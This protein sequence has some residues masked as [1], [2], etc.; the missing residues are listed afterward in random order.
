MSSPLTTDESFSSIISIL[1]MILATFV[2]VSVASYFGWM[3]LPELAAVVL[4]LAIVHH[5]ILNFYTN[6]D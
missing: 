6:N 1:Q 2:I 3:Q 5:S 4:L